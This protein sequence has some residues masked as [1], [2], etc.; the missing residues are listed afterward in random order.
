MPEYPF[1]KWRQLVFVA[2]LIAVLV[3]TLAPPVSQGTIRVRVAGVIPPG[4]VSHVYIRFI[5]V[6]LHVS[7]FPGSS[8]FVTLTQLLPRIDLVQPQ[9]QLALDPLIS[10]KISSG[11]YDEITLQA[12]N[13]TIVNSNGQSIPISIGKSVSA[14][15]TVPVPPNRSGDVLVILNADYV[16][17]ISATPF[18]SL[19]LVQAVGA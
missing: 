6:Q 9:N 2:V 15:V 8:G 17:L 4:I 18:I 13:A 11:R 3:V 1:P 16:Q 14:V 12:D 7:G 10:A 19:S 5:S